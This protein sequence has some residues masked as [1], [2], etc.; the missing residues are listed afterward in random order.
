M[1][2]IGRSDH[3]VRLSGYKNVKL[4]AFPSAP[5]RATSVTTV[6]APTCPTPV[7][8]RI[9]GRR[10]G[11]L[12]L[13][14]RRTYF[15]LDAASAP[16]RPPDDPGN[17]VGFVGGRVGPRRDF[18]A[19]ARARRRVNITDTC[20]CGRAAAGKARAASS[21]S[22]W[23]GGNGDWVTVSAAGALSCC[24]HRLVKNTMITYDQSGASE[25]R[26]M[27]L[28]KLDCYYYGYCIC[29]SFGWTVSTDPLGAANDWWSHD[30]GCCS[31]RWILLT[32]T[33]QPEIICIYFDSQNRPRV[34]AGCEWSCLDCSFMY[35]KWPVVVYRN[36]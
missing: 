15:R 1:C 31:I 32:I 13:D 24:R 35:N 17:R 23:W 9:A 20:W 12:A 30:D 2:D 29:L 21:S 14:A 6:G 27:T 11:R 25:A 22:S 16:G 4:Y 26:Q 8:T 7:E 18:G 19:D 34:Q 36:Y 5:E 28:C 3:A 33:R 10:I